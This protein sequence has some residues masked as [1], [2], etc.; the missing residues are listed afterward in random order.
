MTSKIIKKENY[1]KNEK[2]VDSLSTLNASGLKKEFNRASSIEN[3]ISKNLLRAYILL[4]G[5]NSTLASEEL[6]DLL[7]TNLYEKA[8]SLGKNSRRE[9]KEEKDFITSL[10]QILMQHQV[11][12]KMMSLVVYYLKIGSHDLN[13]T[14]L[15]SE[16]F[17]QNLGLRHPQVFLP[18]LIEKGDHTMI[19]KYIKRIYSYYPESIF[20]DVENISFYLPNNETEREF[21]LKKIFNPIAKSK[22]LINQYRTLLAIQNEVLFKHYFALLK[23][24]EKPYFLLHRKFFL[25]N[26]KINPEISLY[27]FLL[28]GDV[29]IEHIYEL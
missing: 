15:T 11:L 3:K 27:E 1:Y 22:S 13:L 9:E 25:E 7:K 6:R 5:G 24:N 17:S 12:K 8:L 19:K 28:A 23:I 14:K 10:S 21:F 18:L 20:N 26:K 4:L 29:N 2:Y 16:A